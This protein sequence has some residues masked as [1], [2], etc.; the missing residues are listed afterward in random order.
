[1]FSWICLSNLSRPPELLRGP[2]RQIAKEFAVHA[3]GQQRHGPDVFD[4]NS[5]HV[6]ALPARV[7]QNRESKGFKFD[8]SDRIRYVDKA[9]RRWSDSHMSVHN[10]VHN[11]KISTV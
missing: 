1:M 3:N 9:K 4:R 5:E 6:S 10:S 7:R 8:L 11:P 2:G